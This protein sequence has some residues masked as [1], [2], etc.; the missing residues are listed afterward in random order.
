M[1]P[2]YKNRKSIDLGRNI[3]LFLSVEAGVSGVGAIISKIAARWRTRPSL[4]KPGAL[5]MRASRPSRFRASRDG[6]RATG[7]KPENI[8]WI[9]GTG[10]SGSTWLGSLMGDYEG[11]AMWHEPYV[12]EIFGSAYY[13]R[14]WGRQHERESYIMSRPYKD[15]WLNS[16]RNFVLDGADARFPDVEGLLVIK[17]PHG[18]IAAPL[19][20]EALPESRMIF[21]VRDPRDV[22][23]SRLDAHRKGSWTSKLTG[24]NEETLADK[25]PDA[26]AE[27]AANLYLKDME[28]SKEAYDA[29]EGRKSLVKYEEL[30]YDTFGELKRIYSELAIPVEDE[31]LRRV[32]EKHAWENIPENR[33]GLGKS[34][35]KALPGGWR[36]DLT[37]EQV[38]R[39]ERVTAPLLK[40]FYPG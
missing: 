14:A 22:V 12:G 1:M 30:R 29:F 38:R 24:N 18:S 7:V 10:R 26:F 2:V 8:V 40:E 34:H 31:I 9:F 11:H 27:A 35:R 21:L 37:P 17:E 15:V 20:M 3:R 5:S 32:V 6:S 19:L 25:D 16:M 23:S 33:K 39:V 4:P 13:V 28:K 36:E